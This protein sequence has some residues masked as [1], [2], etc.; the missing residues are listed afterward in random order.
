VPYDEISTVLPKDR[1]AALDDPTFAGVDAV[2]EWLADEEP[3]L[4]L[5]LN[6]E[7]VAYP[8][9]ILMWHEIVNDEVGGVPVA[10]TYCPLCN[11]AILFERTVE[12][13]AD[14][15]EARVLD[16]GTTG[17]LRYSNL[18]MYDR[19][20]ESWW[21]QATGEAIAGALTGRTLRFLP[22]SMIAWADFKAAY[23]EGRVLS[24]DTGYERDY[25]RNP[26]PGYDDPDRSPFLYSGP[27]TPDALPQVARVLGIEMEGEAVA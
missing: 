5:E 19:Q 17:R 2:D 22:S 16:F 20:T 10:A 27:E 14:A 4:A 15:G 23:P 9:Q 26:Y 6:G 24:R 8:I 25:G 7:A 21:Q 3:V 13:A 18:I 1:I 12:E 11:T